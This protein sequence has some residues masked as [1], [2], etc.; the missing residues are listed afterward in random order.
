MDYHNLRLEFGMVQHETEE[1]SK[2]KM[3]Q[4]RENRLRKKNAVNILQYFT[5]CHYFEFNMNP[6]SSDKN[7][8]RKKLYKSCK[9]RPILRT[10]CILWYRSHKN[11]QDLLVTRSCNGFH[12]IKKK[13]FIQNNHSLWSLII[14]FYKQLPVIVT[15]NSGR[16]RVTVNSFVQLRAIP[17]IAVWRL[18]FNWELL[19]PQ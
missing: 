15:G 13:V 16:Y 5:F 11:T 12:F 1:W 14:K 3:M 19:H 17:R 6:L 4:N 9:F 2:Y 8:Q 10:F 18:V 7:E